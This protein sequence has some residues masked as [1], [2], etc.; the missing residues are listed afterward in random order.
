MHQRPYQ[1]P[2]AWQKSHNLCM[3]MYTITAL[4]PSHER[5]QMVSQ[6]RRS[7]YGVPM[8]LAEGNARRS[9]K[10]RAHFFEQALSS[11][12]ELHYQI[13][14]SYELGYINQRQFIEADD[15]INRAVY[16][17]TRLRAAIVD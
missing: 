4:F 16:L 5:F 1:K 12:E 11:L 15:R 13:L 2:K 9:K 8:N 17:I 3:W 7:A 6:A 14:L 10:D